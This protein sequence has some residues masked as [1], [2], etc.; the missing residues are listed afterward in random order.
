MRAAFSLTTF[1]L[2]S[3]TTLAVSLNGCQIKHCSC[4][5]N[6]LLFEPEELAGS[7]LCLAEQDRR[8]QHIVQVLGL[9][10]GDDLRVGMLNGN[11][12]TA[13]ILGL[14]NGRLEIEVSLAT[15]PPVPTGIELILAL[16]RPIM[17]QRILKQAT[18]F[19]VS[20]FHLIRSQKVQKSFF[21][22]SVLQAENLRELL[23]QGL[24]QAVDTRLPEVCIHNR[25]R[26]FVE[27]VVPTLKATSRLLAHPVAGPNLAHLH[28][29]DRIGSPL[30]LAIGPE[31]GWSEHEVGAFR[32]QGFTSFSLGP[33]ILHV[34][35]A[36]LVLL[37]QL[38]LLQDL[39]RR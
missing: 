12:G 19:G 18:V 6:I 33:R 16:P 27:D 13:R 10:P 39:R 14:R 34:D 7:L 32:D 36:V 23:L 25:F 5:M 4:T 26:P 37:A 3:F 9:A 11:M 8:V 1:S 20:R 2:N 28:A 17:L 35:T 29:T 38:Q 22:G 31:G 21:Q 15:P 24:A 30:L